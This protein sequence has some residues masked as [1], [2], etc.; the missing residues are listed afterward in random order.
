MRLTAKDLKALGVIDRIIAEPVGGAHRGAKET[1]AAVGKALEVEL[2]AL[3]RK[4]PNE[5]R[6]DRR[7]K[8]L[9]MGAKGLAA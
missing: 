8:F 7:K 6:A 1:I 5:L 3:A 2:A 9:G 4:P